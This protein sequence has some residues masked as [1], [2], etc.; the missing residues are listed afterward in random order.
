MQHYSVVLGIPRLRS[1]N[2]SIDWEAGGLTFQPSKK[3]GATPIPVNIVP[4]VDVLAAAS[5]FGEQLVGTLDAVSQPEENSIVID[6]LSRSGEKLGIPVKCSAPCYI[7]HWNRYGLEVGIITHRLACPTQHEDGTI[8][9]G[10][11]QLL[12]TFY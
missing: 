5:R 9:S 1:H 3:R 10:I 8:L 12:S 11:L 4:A 6:S 7:T 2:L